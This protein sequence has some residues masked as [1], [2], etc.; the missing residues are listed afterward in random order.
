S[1]KEN[2]NA[3]RHTPTLD[4]EQINRAI[5]KANS[6]PDFVD[7]AVGQLDGLR[8]PGFK[9]NIIEYSKS[10]NVAKDAVALFG[11]LNGY[12]EFRDQYHVAKALHENVTAKKMEF[13]ISDEERESPNVKTRSTAVDAST[14]ERE[15]VN[16]N[17]ERKDY[18]E[19]TPTAMSNFIGDRC[20]KPFQNQQDLIQHQQFESGTVT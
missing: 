5:E 20:G 14:K 8:F 9:R 4:S 7:Y 6:D 1:T 11:S 3:A 17:E 15:A 19:V 12:M 10:R 18:P 16:A 2:I 13:Q